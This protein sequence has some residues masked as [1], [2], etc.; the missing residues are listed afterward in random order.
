MSKDVVIV[1]SSPYQTPGSFGIIK[2]TP[3]NTKQQFIE[4]Q[5]CR[6]RFQSVSEPADIMSFVFCYKP[7]SKGNIIEFMRTLEEVIDKGPGGPLPDEDRLKFKDTNNKN[8]LYVEMSKWWK[9]RVR[10]S[11]LTALLRTG[12]DYV[13]HTGNGFEKCLSSHQYLSDNRYALDRFL[14]G[15]WAVKM[16][17]HDMFPG[18][19][20]AFHGKTPAQVNNILVKLKKKK[21][22]EGA[23]E[24]KL[25]QT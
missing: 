14:S 6:D 11:L 18:W 16:R 9:Y 23:G 20:H 19:Y 24:A 15:A 2:P 22:G 3:G 12:Q 5:T 8:C 25:A 21:P 1:P 17:K 4:W 7:N 10:R 13:D